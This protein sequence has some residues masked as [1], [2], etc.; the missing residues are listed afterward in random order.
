MK[1]ENEKDFLFKEVKKESTSNTNWLSDDGIII[2][3]ILIKLIPAT[4]ITIGIVCL[5]TILAVQVRKMTVESR[6][7]VVET[8][9]TANDNNHAT[10]DYIFDFLMGY[11]TDCILSDE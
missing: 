10:E 5:V 1:K 9:D 11:Y 6:T 7:A 4:L 8:S 2:L 3:D